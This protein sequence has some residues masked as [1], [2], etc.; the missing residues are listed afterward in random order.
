M[1]AVAKTFDSHT[2]KTTSGL[3][4]RPKTLETSPSDDSKYV[5][6]ITNA[7][8]HITN[9]Y[10]RTFEVLLMAIAKHIG[11]RAAFSAVNSTS[12]SSQWDAAQRLRGLDGEDGERDFGDLDIL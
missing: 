7:T 4:T 3:S 1:N 12:R 9:V 11:Q 6:N 5:R 10:A 8:A 2:A